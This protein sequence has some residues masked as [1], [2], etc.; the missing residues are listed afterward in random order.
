MCVQE[1]TWRTCLSRQDRNVIVF[2]GICHYV[3]DLVCYGRYCVAVSLV[4]FISRDEG[5][6]EVVAQ[7]Q[8][9]DEGLDKGLVSLRFRTTWLGRK[10]NG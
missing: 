2:C 4:V 3:S 6:F 5:E 7:C 10:I 9:E 8:R 1:N